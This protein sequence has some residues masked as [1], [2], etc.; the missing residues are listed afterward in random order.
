MKGNAIEIS[1]TKYEENLTCGYRDM[2]NKQGLMQTF[3]VNVDEQRDEQT[4][5]R[6]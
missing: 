1:Y 5:E 4:N 3:D 6:T 2:S